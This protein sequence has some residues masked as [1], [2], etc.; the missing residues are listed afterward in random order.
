MATLTVF[1]HERAQT[2]KY[3][4]KMADDKPVANHN[5][6]NINSHPVENGV[7]NGVDNENGNSNL[8]DFV[9]RSYHDQRV[10]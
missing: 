10:S 5:G 8:L 6:L 2:K 3:F 4:S 7:E 9:T 1:Y